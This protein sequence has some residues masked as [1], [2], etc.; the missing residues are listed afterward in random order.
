MI[1]L[2]F[3]SSLVAK[4]SIPERQ[5][6]MDQGFDS[7]TLQLVEVNVIVRREEFLLSSTFDRLERSQ[8][9]Y[10]YSFLARLAHTQNDVWGLSMYRLYISY[11]ANISGE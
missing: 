9:C 8:H 3:P 11:K 5:E 1:W 7:K 4:R 2:P 6:G 10:S